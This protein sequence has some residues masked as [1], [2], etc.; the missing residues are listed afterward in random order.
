MI[1]GTIHSFKT[2]E[3][4]QKSLEGYIAALKAESENLSKL[5][6]EKMRSTDSSNAA[7]MQELKQKLEGGG[8]DPKKKN[9]PKKKDQK[10]NWYAF[11]S[12]SIYDGIGLK[13][14]LEL[15][16]KAMEKTKSELEM[17]TKVKQSIDSLVSK[18]LKRDMGCILHLGEALPAE[19]AFTNTSEPRKKFSLRMVFEVPI[20]SNRS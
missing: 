13:G 1:S 14:E 6:G 4:M 5:I 12:L 15:Y 11:D 8:A 17:V 9:A 16:F 19:I 20:E 2:P 7:E 3:E 10:A 18:G